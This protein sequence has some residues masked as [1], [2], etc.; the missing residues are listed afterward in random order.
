MN[1]I[2]IKIKKVNNGIRTHAHN[3]GSELESDA[4]DRSAMLT[5]YFI[6]SYYYY[7]H[8]TKQFSQKSWIAP[9][10]EY[11]TTKRQAAGS[12][13]DKGFYKLMINTDTNYQ[14]PILFIIN[15]NHHHH[16]YVPT[17]FQVYTT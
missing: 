13:F 1:T 2:F 14:I 9:Y 5:Y 16:K 12:D 11:N 17:P 6:I 4:L 15:H 10:I 3:C 8:F 7:H